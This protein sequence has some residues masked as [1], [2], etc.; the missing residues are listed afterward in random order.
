MRFSFSV[1][2]M[3][4][5]AAAASCSVVRDIFTSPAPPP[6]PFNHAAH[7]DRG[8]SCL[9]CHAGGEKEI[10][11]GMPT[12]DSCMVCHEDIDKEPLRAKEKTVAWFLDDTGQPVWSSFTGQS[13]EIR[14]AHTNHK[15]ACTVCHAGIDKDTGLVPSRPQRMDSCMSCHQ[16]EAPTKND[17]AT[18]HTR[19]DRDVAPPSHAMGWTQR[20]GMCARAGAGSATANDCAMCHGKDSCSS[21]HSTQAPGDHNGVWRFRAHGLA[22]SLDRTRCATCHASDYCV[23]CHSESSPRSHIAGWDAPRNRH[24]MGCHEPLRENN[25]CVVCHSSTPGHGSAAPKPS[26]HTAAM[27]CRS[28]HAQSMKHFDNG[29]NCNACHK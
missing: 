12:K 7:I 14:F 25:S 24:C 22:A 27:N 17:C 4:I 11:A 1:A 18:C 5:V 26:W 23:R 16:R 28:C 8:I 3:A 29:D 20:H 19:I 10:K 9:D 13:D 2:L 15:Q 21:C 6:R